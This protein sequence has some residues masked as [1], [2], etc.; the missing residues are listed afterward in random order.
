MKGRM[1]FQIRAK[2]E[3][4]FTARYDIVVISAAER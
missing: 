4:A 3:G 1:S 2:K